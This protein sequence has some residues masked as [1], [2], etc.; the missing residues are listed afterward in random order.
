M[1]LPVMYVQLVNIVEELVWTEV[2]R[3]MILVYVAL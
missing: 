1:V 2:A 3:G